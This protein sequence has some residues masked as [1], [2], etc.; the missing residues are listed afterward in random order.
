MA[1]AFRTWTGTILPE[2]A[3]GGASCVDGVGRGFVSAYSVG[4]LGRLANLA[5]LPSKPEAR[6]WAGG[7]PHSRRNPWQPQALVSANL[8]FAE[9]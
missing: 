1:V 9:R 8:D 7:V 3:R 4:R 5:R 6:I 2:E